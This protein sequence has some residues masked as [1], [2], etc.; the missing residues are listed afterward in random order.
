MPSRRQAGPLSRWVAIYLFSV[1]RLL[2]CVRWD[3]NSNRPQSSELKSASFEVPDDVG[4]GSP[5]RSRDTTLIVSKLLLR[6][7]PILQ[8]VTSCLQQVLVLSLFWRVLTFLQADRSIATSF[9]SGIFGICSTS[10]SVYFTVLY[11]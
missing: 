3:S 8:P 1:G 2:V 7:R 5:R 10:S 11:Y 6:R 4:S 9:Q